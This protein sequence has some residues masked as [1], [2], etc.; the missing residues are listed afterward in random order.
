M[1]RRNFLKNGTL[2]TAA[3][4]ILPRTVLGGVGHLAPSDQI[5]LGIIGCGAQ[6]R[7]TLAPEFARRANLVAAADCDSIRLQAMQEIVEGET[8]KAKG[9]AYK[10][11]KQYADY[12]ELLAR[13]DIDGVIIATPDHWHAVQTIEACRA[14]KDVYVEKPMSHSIAE[15]RAMADAVAK[16]NRV[17]Q[18]GNMQRSWR[19]F[20]HACELVR[21]GYIGKIKE[22]QVSVGPPPIPYDLSAQPV[23]KHVNWEKWIGPGPMKPYNEELLPP[24]EKKV[25]PN[26]RNYKEFGGGM[27]TD[28]GAHMFDIAQW[29]M[30]M[31]DSGPVEFIPADGKDY[32]ALTMYYA[33]GTVMTHEQFRKD[34]GNGVRFIGDNGVIDISRSFLDTIPAKLQNHEI[35]DN[36]IKLYRSNDHY[37][38]FLNS[39]KTRKQP[40]S[41]VEVGHRTT[42]LCM[43]VN[44]CY[45]L[46]RKLTWNPEKEEF[47]NDNEA[48]K[49]RSNPIRAPY[50]L[51]V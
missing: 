3:F 47:A 37:N 36:E 39:M 28:W 13:K 19:N 40:L 42:S 12:K 43:I 18:V 2:A 5:S 15:G 16:Y 35:K 29:A 33:D 1:N 10:G 24:I 44:L 30:G 51:N 6:G 8:T 50:N 20:R 9:Q 49:L 38:D 22:I 23:P 41:T 32:K 25:F 14:G 34:E 27:I 45:E 26:W 31:D 11:F 7:W 48:N 4:T 17:L 21:N 46:K